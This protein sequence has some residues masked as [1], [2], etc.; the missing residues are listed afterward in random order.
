ML[1]VMYT[2]SGPVGK[3]VAAAAANH[4]TPITLEVTWIYNYNHTHSSHH[5]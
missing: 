5:L 3:V 1:L 4:L 2:G